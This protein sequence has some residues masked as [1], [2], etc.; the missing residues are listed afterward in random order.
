MG[1]S[2]DAILCFGVELGEDDEAPSFM[3]GFDE[4]DDFLMNEGGQPRWGE[5][6]HSFDKQRE[7]LA[8][9][10][11]EMVLH[12]SGDYPMYILAVRGTVTTASRGYPQAVTTEDPD[13]TQVQRYMSWL[14]DHG[15]ED[16]P[17][18]LICSMW[19]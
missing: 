12:C 18:W 19:N 17:K 1:Q 8:A 5:A 6:G 7:W 10:P 13:H 15:I 16:E 9:Q 4:F 11:V 14:S 3:E 2:T